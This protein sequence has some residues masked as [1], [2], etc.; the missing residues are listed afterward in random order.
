MQVLECMYI[1]QTIDLLQV[2]HSSKTPE[3]LESESS[4]FLLPFCL[5]IFHIC[6][7]RV[8][9][10]Q[11][12]TNRVAMIMWDA[13]LSLRSCGLWVHCWSWMTEPRWRPSWR[14]VKVFFDSITNLVFKSNEPVV[15]IFTVYR[16]GITHLYPPP[17]LS[18]GLGLRLWPTHGPGQIL[19]P[20]FQHTDVCS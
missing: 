13:C 4:K 8:C 17:P 18:R 1:K 10:Q 16:G 19:V 7:F 15:W 5:V 12:R 9:S 11:R 20:L 3:K 2:G 14:C 6:A